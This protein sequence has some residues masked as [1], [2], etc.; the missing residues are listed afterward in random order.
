MDEMWVP[1]TWE[2]EDEGLMCQRLE[3]GMGEVMKRSEGVTC[4][5]SHSLRFL[6]CAFVLHFP[7]SFTLHLIPL[8]QF[9]LELH[10]G[11]L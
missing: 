8:S 10:I 7:T 1:E 4:M 3:K 5:L 11:S 6:P 2:K 9:Q